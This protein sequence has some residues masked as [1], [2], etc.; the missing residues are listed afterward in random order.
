MNEFKYLNS[1][2][3]AAIDVETTGSIP[4]QYDIIQVAVIPLTYA[5]KPSEEFLP[6]LMDIAPKRP[7]S[8]EWEAMRVNKLQLCDIMLNGVDAYLA[9]DR[10]MEWFDRLGLGFQKRLIP[11]GANY[12]FDRGFLIDWLGNATYNL[13]FNSDFRDVL[14][15][16]DYRNDLDSWRG[17]KPRFE[18]VSLG[19]LCA[20]YKV[21]RMRAHDAT[22]DARCTAEVYRHLLM[23]W[24]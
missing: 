2:V 21:E 11:V 17:E 4:H 8:I 7:D 12:C 3:F 5:L 24:N 1:H 22:D 14:R 15:I 16:A 18:R 13:I 6:F 10:F 20:K 23:E 19:S 9:A